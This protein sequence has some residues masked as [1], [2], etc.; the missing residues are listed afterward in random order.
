MSNRSDELEAVLGSLAGTLRAQAEEGMRACEPS[1]ASD[2]V[3]LAEAALVRTAADQDDVAK[4]ALRPEV[5]SAP[6]A[7][8]STRDGQE[9]SARPS[10]LPASKSPA[11]QPQPEPESKPLRPATPERTNS[12]D[13][14]PWVPR[15]DGA[16]P[17]G[18]GSP[19]LLSIR[20]EIGDC[21]RCDL[22]ARRTNIV[23][24]VG[25][26]T[27]RLMFV[28]EGP[29]ADE[30]RQGEPFVGR[31]GQLLTKMIGA[32]GLQRSDV[33]IANVVKCRPPG[34]RDP[35]PAEVA[36]CRPFLDQQIAAV[37]PEAIVCLGRVAATA[38]LDRD[39]AITRE[40]GSWTSYQGVPVML[41]LHPAYLLRQS[42]AK[43]EAWADLQMVMKRL[44]LTRPGGKG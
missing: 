39:V 11:N 4:P 7:A 25:S 23:F 10:Q 36:K 34:N 32:M 29:G 14:P 30:D 21:E 31:A 37:A 9:P 1:L 12:R 16:A 28:G 26:P 44:G 42:Q 18:V 27:A 33:Y 6:P 15:R 38:L 5:A 13:S 19:A 20:D 40:R 24:G 8:G 41:T 17:K 22:C 35:L 3:R 2:L 43:A